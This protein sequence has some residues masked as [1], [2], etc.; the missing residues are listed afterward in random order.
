MVVLDAMRGWRKEGEARKERQAEVGR[1]LD[2]RCRV[3]DRPAC[4][5]VE[6]IRDRFEWSLLLLIRG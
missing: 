3:A 1:C 6:G 5:V 4:L 2:P